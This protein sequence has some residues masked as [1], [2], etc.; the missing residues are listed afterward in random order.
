MACQIEQVKG[1]GVLPGHRISFVDHLVPLCQI[2]GIP[3]LCTD[4]WV[5]E[6]IGLYYPP[7]E[8]IL[9]EA[10]DFCL[11]QSLKEY[12]TLFY[13]TFSRQPHGS[14]QFLEY[15]SNKKLRSV[16]SLHGNSDK[17]RNIFWAERFAD[18]DIVLLYGDHMIDFIKEKGVLDRIPHR[19]VTGNYR[20]EFYRQNKPFF[21]QFSFFPKD[22][23]KTILYAPTWSSDN[24]RS[25]WKCDYSSFFEAHHA[26]FS[27]IPEDYRLIVKLHPHLIYESADE[28][29]KVKAR[30]SDSDQLFFLG[31]IPPIFP[32]LEHV[33]IYL[34]DYSSIGY[35]FLAFNRPLFFLNMSERDPESDKGVHLF[36]CGEVIDPNQLENVYQIIEGTDSSQFEK[37]RKESYAY[38][39]GEKSS[40]FTG[41]R[42]EVEAALQS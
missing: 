18:E 26:L 23:R 35:D 15:H 4:P 8:L 11:D 10:P 13:V 2:M 14:F 38:A 30:Y 5:F 3:L 21:D 1:I 7:M 12:N 6:A 9:D 34:G 20:L 42:Q 27:S 40:D 39:F 37:A 28:I 19:I 33:D 32:I 25:A 36:R 24:L 17:K 22:D 16:Y 31:D 29:E 41:L